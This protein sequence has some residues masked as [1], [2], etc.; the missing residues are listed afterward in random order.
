MEPV[1][2]QETGKE[3]V[4][5]RCESA[6]HWRPGRQGQSLVRA[7]PSQMR[8]EEIWGTFLGKE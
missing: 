1:R 3:E 2:R 7:G 5:R 6:L 8:Q 4:G